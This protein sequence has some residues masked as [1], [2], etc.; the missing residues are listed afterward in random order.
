MD[1]PAFAPLFIPPDCAEGGRGRGGARA[2]QREEAVS[3]GGS[4]RALFRS[5][6]ASYSRLGSLLG[7]IPKPGPDRCARPC[8]LACF[9]SFL[10]LLPSC[11]DYLHVV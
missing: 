5:C 9:A 10:F 2:G 7:P 8:F 11:L 4:V 6:Q 3:Q 1:V